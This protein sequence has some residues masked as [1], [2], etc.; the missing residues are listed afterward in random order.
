MAQAAFF[1]GGHSVVQPALTPH[2][3][4]AVMATDAG[5]GYGDVQVVND[6]RFPSGCGGVARGARRWSRNQDGNMQVRTRIDVATSIVA[7]GGRSLRV[8]HCSN[9]CS[10]DRAPPEILYVGIG[11]AISAARAGSRV[12]RHSLS[13]RAIVA[14]STCRPSNCLT[15]VKCLDR[16]PHHPD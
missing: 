15:V 6:C 10:C 12:I 5:V 14:T 1:V 11:V 13:Q 16:R 9:G 4:G 2:V 7:S 8:I 3:I